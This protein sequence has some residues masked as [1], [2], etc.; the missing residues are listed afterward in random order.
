MNDFQPAD[1]AGAAIPHLLKQ[2]RAWLI[3]IATLGILL[4]LFLLA[5][6]AL[7]SV[8]HKGWTTF[9]DHDSVS[10]LA[11][12]KQ[13]RTWAAVYDISPEGLRMESIVMYPNEGE[14]IEIPLPNELA[15]DA[16]QSLAI[17][18]QDRVWVRPT[19]NDIIG[20]R[21]I[22]GQWALYH[23]ESIEG[24]SAG[25]DIVID[26][27]DQA[28]TNSPQIH[29]LKL[30]RIELDASRN[31]YILA[32]TALTDIDTMATDEKGQLWVLR[33]NGDIKTLS[34]D[35]NWMSYAHATKEDPD[36]GD[37][38]TS[39]G[40]AC[41]AIDKQGQ[42]WLGVGNGVVSMLGLDGVWKSYSPDE[43]HPTIFTENIVV[44]D[45][46]HMWGVSGGQGLY[47][48]HPATGWTPYNTRN[49]GLTATYSATTLATD[50]QGRVWVGTHDG[51][52]VTFD[53]DAALPVQYLPALSLL[54]V[55][56]IPSALI[57]I[58]LVLVWTL[59]FTRP[60]TITDKTSPRF[61]MIA[62]GSF[63]AAAGGLYALGQREILA[64]QIMESL[65]GDYWSHNDFF[66]M[67]GAPLLSICLVPVA[68]IVGAGMGI[69]LVRLSTQA[70]VT[71]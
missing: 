41:L 68:V 21:D 70:F 49:S 28:W 50:G 63:G 65:F 64:G 2:R 37:A 6:I 69:L 32:N 57:S 53:P 67:V 31:M 13:G 7:Q 66:A 24:A 25:F 29:G 17:D 18:R 36:V 33:A 8:L 22:N 51:G 27:Q 5:E 47:R 9:T 52:L 20:I 3:R 16:V 48:F 23:S 58:A 40:S 34:P 44:D 30:V 39:F 54:G 4:G 19:N 14:P 1:I 62:L 26:G 42:V 45:Q 38:F 56:V 11:I 10:D 55:I 60:G 46:G 12:D 35:S 61:W 15:N 71:R 59:V 43:L